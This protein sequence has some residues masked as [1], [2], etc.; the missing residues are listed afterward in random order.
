MNTITWVFCFWVLGLDAPHA[1][2][3]LLDPELQPLTVKSLVLGV[4]VEND[5]ALTRYDLTYFNP[6]D[7][8][9]EA[10][11]DF[12]LPGEALIQRFAMEVE[13]VLREAVVVDAAEGRRA[14]E[15][16]VSLKVDP[17]LVEMVQGR[18]FRADVYPVPALG[19]KRLVIEIL[20]QLP[21]DGRTWVYRPP[22][23]LHEAVDSGRFQITVRGDLERPRARGSWSSRLRMR[24][25][26]NGW[27]ARMPITRVPNDLEI[28]MHTRSDA[29]VNAAHRAGLTSFRLVIPNVHNSSRAIHAQQVNLFWDVSGSARDRDLALERELLDAYLKRVGELELTVVPFSYQV[30][31]VAFFQIRNGDARE[32]H[33]YLDRLLIDGASCLAS[34]PFND[35]PADMG[36]LVS[37]GVSTFCDEIPVVPDYPTHAIASVTQVDSQMLR[38]LVAPSGGY[39]LDLTELSVDRAVDQL[40]RVAEVADLRVFP[41]EGEPHIEVHPDAVVVVGQTYSDVL[42]VSRRGRPLGRFHLTG[43]GDWATRIWANAEIARA[44]LQQ[45]D[46][47]DAMRDLA[48][49]CG[50]VTAHT[51][52][53]VLEQAWQYAQYGIEPPESLRV[54]Y[55]EALMNMQET[56]TDRLMQAQS[57]RQELKD[58]REA[59]QQWFATDFPIPEPE[60][61]PAP[62]PTETDVV[63]AASDESETGAANQLQPSE[64]EWVPDDVVRVVGEPG[65][66]DLEMEVV[67]I[68]DV[69]M[70][71]SACTVVMNYDFAEELMTVG[72]GGVAPSLTV[73]LA[74]YDEESTYLTTLKN[75]DDDALMAT[76]Q[77]LRAEFADSP[78]FFLDVARLLWEQGQAELAHRA[79]S[80]IAELIPDSHDV[81]RLMAM[82]YEYYGYDW[83]AIW[84]FDQVTRKRPDLPQAW[85]E[86]ALVYDHVGETDLAIELLD[87]VIEGP[88]NDDFG[89]EL[90]A[91]TEQIEL[92]EKH[93]NLSA[94]LY[95]M[96]DGFPSDLRVVM[97][98]DTPYTDIDLWLEHPNGEKCGYSHPLDQFGARLLFDDTSGYGPEVVMLR[99]ALPGTYQIR[100]DLYDDSR[101]AFF[102]PI[103]VKVDIFRNYGR[104]NQTRTTHFVRFSEEHEEDDSLLITELHID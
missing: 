3:K 68:L 55:E 41:L 58:E 102:G 15:D 46:D 70:Q 50:L 52:L 10:R 18:T 95:T 6:N 26:K 24:Q 80:N 54:E 78:S 93:K 69:T 47:G 32:L 21:R 67:L 92:L 28:A 98:W 103:S 42:H 89:I 40:R 61:P 29:W 76:Y 48:L 36:I 8:D 7:V 56:E 1:Q 2:L 96:P 9:V 31:D 73:K 14:Y 27:S 90:V 97:N 34:V 66:V 44:R 30:E 91:L 53:I 87:R 22:V 37:D 86:L 43:A 5:L 57:R 71:T 88:W 77:V 19:T 20:D 74:A 4:E 81:L 65:E 75:T 60:A 79:L 33:A 72:S 94:K 101:T 39:V 85:R 82:H 104:P 11:L 100:V 35:Y 23:Q 13:G 63:T 17:G 84:A 16:I 49:E 64:P 62:E 12:P 83:D 99:N 51:S 45:M 25:T 59:L 38:Q